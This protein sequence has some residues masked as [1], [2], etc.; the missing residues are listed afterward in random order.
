MSTAPANQESAAAKADDKVHE[1]T[2]EARL[3][4]AEEAWAKDN[5][6]M[7]PHTQRG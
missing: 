6:G 5:R 7:V 4:F 2:T 3:K 1:G